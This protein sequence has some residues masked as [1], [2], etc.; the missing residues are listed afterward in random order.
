MAYHLEDEDD[1]EN[2]DEKLLRM[3]AARYDLVIIGTGMGGGVLAYAL[4]DSGMK[5]LLI[6]RGDF[7]PQE[8]ENWSPEAVFDHKRY[9]PNETF[10]W[11]QYQGLWRRTSP[12]QKRGFLRARTRRRNLAR[13]A[14]QL[15]RA[16]TIL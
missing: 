2:E 8:P 9:K 13:L 5:I 11:R 16:R 10:R 1:D 6:E 4:K 12:A 14:H 7:L 15:R 3:T